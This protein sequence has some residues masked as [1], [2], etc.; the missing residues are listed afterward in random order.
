M[1]ISRL[2]ATSLLFSD[3]E[4][5]VKL[6]LDS[7]LLTHVSLALFPLNK[8]SS[9]V[10]MTVIH[11][12]ASNLPIPFDINNA[13]EKPRKIYGSVTMPLTA[14]KL[15]LTCAKVLLKL[16]IPR[17]IRKFASDMSTAND[18]YREDL[19]AYLLEVATALLYWQNQ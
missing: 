19:T 9:R 5:A 11:F 3:E 6:C 18:K 1:Q 12:T 10:N 13:H 7:W 2:R 16:Q 15:M 17:K 4:L 8:V 14:T